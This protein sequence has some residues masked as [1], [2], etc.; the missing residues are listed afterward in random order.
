MKS[1]S[2]GKQCIQT[3]TYNSYHGIIAHQ[4]PPPHHHRVR[5]EY[6]IH[7]HSSGMINEEEEDWSSCSAYISF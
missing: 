2:V 6:M 5:Y 3:V 1:F 4:D 7:D